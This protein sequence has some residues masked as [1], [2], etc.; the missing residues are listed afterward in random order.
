MHQFSASRPSVL[1]QCT[2]KLSVSKT[3]LKSISAQCDIFFSHVK[4]FDPSPADDG[5]PPLLPVVAGMD[6]RNPVTPEDVDITPESVDCAVG[7]QRPM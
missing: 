3:Q 4:H 1:C 2:K 7:L 6:L 5:N